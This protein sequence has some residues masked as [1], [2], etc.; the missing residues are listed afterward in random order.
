M[1]WWCRDRED[2]LWEELLGL[3]VKPHFQTFR[4]LDP[5]RNNNDRVIIIAVVLVT[6]GIFLTSAADEPVGGAA[7][8]K[9]SGLNFSECTN[10]EKG[11]GSPGH[12]PG[13]HRGSQH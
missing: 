5:E 12:R 4:L 13:E 6:Q 2:G 1:Y 8:A 7:A 3:T 10:K 9:K 11:P